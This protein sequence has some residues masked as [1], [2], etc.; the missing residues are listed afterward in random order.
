MQIPMHLGAGL[1]GGRL[2]PSS[3]TCQSCSKITRH[4]VQFGPWMRWNNR[5]QRRQS[6]ILDPVCF[7]GWLIGPLLIMPKLA[8]WICPQMFRA[9]V[10]RGLCP[11]GLVFNVPYVMPLLLQCLANFVVPYYFLACLNGSFGYLSS[12]PFAL[13]LALLSCYERLCFVPN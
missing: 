4:S 12:T 10:G 13:S 7:G 6:K 2:A 8:P 11:M 3:Q 5:S 1:G 9:E